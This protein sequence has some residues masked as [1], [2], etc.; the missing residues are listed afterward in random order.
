MFIVA[1]F[2]FVFLNDFSFASERDNPIDSCWRTDSNWE[3]NRMKLADCAKGFGSSA[4]GG[5]GGAIYVVTSAGDDAVNPKPGTLRYGATRKGPLW[6]IFGRNLHIRLAMPL[7]ID[8]SKT[9]DGRGANVHI[10]YGGP[11]FFIQEVSNVII[12]GLHFHECMTSVLGDV[13]IRESYGVE[14]VHPQDGDAIT[15]RTATDVWI[16]HNTL[17]NCSDGL[18]D[19]T[20]ASTRVTVSNNRFFDHSK[21]MLLGHSDSYP[22]DKIMKVTVAFNQFGPNCGQRMPRAR[23]GH[24]HVANNNYDPWTIYAIGGSLHPTII[25][26]GNRFIA[27]DESYKKMVTNRVGCETSSAC[28]GWVWRSV[29]DLFFNGAYFSQSGSSVKTGN[30]YKTKQIFKVESG[31]A[32]PV[33]TRNAG[34]LT[35][36]PSKPCSRYG[37]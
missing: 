21:V 23:F 15:V 32:V 13:L 18:V 3:Q 20:L 29:R 9:I 19:V 5:K 27:P 7:F 1:A 2:V 26:D 34:V 10:G 33:L 28:A 35:C 16:D 31:S 22:R 25:S 4:M 12:H 8:G 14:P 17:S 24:I 6:I 37:T 11:C 36:N 30:D